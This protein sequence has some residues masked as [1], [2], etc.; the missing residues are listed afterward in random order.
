MPGVALARG[1][2]RFSSVKR[3]YTVSKGADLRV[4]GAVS[5][6]RAVVDWSVHRPLI[7]QRLVR[8]SW[9]DLL[10][11]TLGSNGK[12]AFTLPKPHSGDYRV[13]YPGCPHFAET[14][15][16]FD[17]HGGTSKTG[18]GSSAKLDPMLSLVGLHV[19]Y[20]FTGSG[21]GRSVQGMSPLLVP[22]VVSVVT[23][24]SP[25]AMAGY[26]LRYHVLASITGATYTPVFEFPSAVSFSGG[27]T[28]QLGAVVPSRDASNV[29][30]SAYKVVATWGGNRFT[31]P[32]TV[33]AT[34]TTLR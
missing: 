31:V 20:G 13:L 8:S 27:H 19:T 28:L 9:K 12:F 7:V 21:S 16:C 4:S 22:L 3:S 6:G 33:E 10:V 34:T 26:Y 25:E 18:V 17:V 30:F 14:A 23:S 29:W 15:K 11:V 5:S 1:S 24:Q 2:V 32:A